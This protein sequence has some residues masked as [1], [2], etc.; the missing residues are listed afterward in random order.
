MSSTDHKAPGFW[1]TFRSYLV[2][3]SV[4]SVLGGVLGLL[5][6]ILMVMLVRS[7][8]TTDNPLAWW[9]LGTALSFPV[10]CFVCPL[11]A[12]QV[13]QSGRNM[14]AAIVLLLPLITGIT[15]TSLWFKIDTFCGGQLLC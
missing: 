10:I 9:F 2:A 5:P 12:Y 7:G 13:Y 6:A 14:A 4:L 1:G 11:V 8:G 15:F 3:G